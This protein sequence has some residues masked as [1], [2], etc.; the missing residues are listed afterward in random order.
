MLDTGGGYI[1][2]GPQPPRAVYCEAQSAER[3]P[4]LSRI[5]T[6]ERVA[7]LRAAGYAHPGHAPNDSKSYPIDGMSD[8]AIADELLTLLHEV[9]GY[10]GMP[11]L[12]FRTEKNS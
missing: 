11:E 12:V 1:Q 7:R 10:D 4:V 9:Y 3:W 6:A 2:C 8:T 5:L